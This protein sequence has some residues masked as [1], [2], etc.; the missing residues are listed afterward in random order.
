MK[1]NT[2]GTNDEQYPIVVNE[3]VSH[4]RDNIKLHKGQM[5]VE[6]GTVVSIVPQ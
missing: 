6:Y 3:C 2:S 4:C 1:V 5:R